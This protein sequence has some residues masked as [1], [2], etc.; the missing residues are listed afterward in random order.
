MNLKVVTV[1]MLDTGIGIEAGFKDD[2]DL[3]RHAR[4]ERAA[5]DPLTRE[6]VDKIDAEVDRRWLWGEPS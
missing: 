6:I 4:A 1:P 5:M 3:I 2:A